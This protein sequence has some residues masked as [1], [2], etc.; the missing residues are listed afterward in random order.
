MTTG[1]PSVLSCAAIMLLL[2][3]ARAF[4]RPIGPAAL[5]GA[6]W[7]KLAGSSQTRAKAGGPTRMA[8]ESEDDKIM[9][10]FGAA[11]AS[12]TD[13]FKK[14]LSLEER[15]MALQGFTDH[16]LEKKME[17]DPTQ[18]G[19]K[20]N[21]ILDA[22]NKEMER[23]MAEKGVG[24]LAAAAKVE[25]AVQTASGLVVQTVLEGTGSEPSGEDTVKAR[26]A[27]R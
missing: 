5:S 13:Q 20:V 10:A 8:V 21:N 3:A 16:W 17:L 22:R 11:L 1:A 26:Y 19:E 27:T 14:L 12:Q 15:S 6:R 9:Y 4:V 23:N 25:G 24:F 18:Y 2:P 7:S